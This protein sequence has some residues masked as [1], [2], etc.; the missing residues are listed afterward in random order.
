LRWQVKC[1]IDNGKA[2][3]PFQAQLRRLKDR[4]LPYTPNLDDDIHTIEQGIR[5]VQWV[6]AMLPLK[7]VTVLEV[8]SGWQ[9]MIPV[10]YSLA[11]AS[12]VYL[13][14]LNVLLRPDTFSAALHALRTQRPLIV[15]DL[16]VD[17]EM[18]DHALREDPAGSMK[19]RLEELHLVYLAPCDCRKLAL[20]A[21]SLDVVTSRACLEHIPPDVLQDIFHESYR[22]LKHGGLACHWVDPSD[23]WEH[24]DKSLSRVNFLK[25][26]DALFRWTYINPINYQNRLRHPEY[27]ELLGKAGFR[28]VREERKVDEASLRSLPHMRIAE[29]FRRFSYEDLATVDSLLLAIKD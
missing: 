5:Q 27:V 6:N 17:A 14:D 3:L 10:L 4:F 13:T 29:R 23:H 16:K 20:P 2:L 15:N 12:R 24:Q 19:E 28:L 7:G 22:L 8:G 11:G 9:P 21:E 18:L 25:Y 1:T 26:S